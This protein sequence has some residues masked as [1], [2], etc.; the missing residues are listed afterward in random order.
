MQAG[1]Y[2][3]FFYG[4]DNFVAQVIEV[5]K[6]STLEEYLNTVTLEKALP[7]IATV[8]E[9]VKIYLQWSSREEIEKYGFLGIFVRPIST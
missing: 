4:S 8:E 6:F 3:K 7:G 1:D 5:K 2:I 9:A